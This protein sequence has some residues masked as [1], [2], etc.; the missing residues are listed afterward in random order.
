MKHEMK[1]NK[2]KEMT[3]NGIVYATK[4]KQS[5]RRKGTLAPRHNR[6]KEN[7]AKRGPGS[8]RALVIRKYYLAL[9]LYRSTQTHPAIPSSA[10]ML[11]KYYLALWHYGTTLGFR[12][13]PCHGVPSTVYG[14]RS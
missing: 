5:A 14:K 3:Q 11:A 9:R 7:K 12:T 6:K 4:N 10:A 13:E 2:N 1:Q 8:S